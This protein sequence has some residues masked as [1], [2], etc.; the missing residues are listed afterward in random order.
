MQIQISAVYILECLFE[1]ITPEVAGLY[2]G[3]ILAAVSKLLTD[4]SGA[5]QERGEYSFSTSGPA[6]SLPPACF[7]S[8]FS[9][10]LVAVV[11]VVVAAAAAAV[12][13]VRGRGHHCRCHF[14][15]PSSAS[16]APRLTH[17][18]VVVAAAAAVVVVVVVD[19]TVAASLLEGLALLS[20]VALAS[21]KNFAPHLV[22]TMA[23]MFKLMDPSYKDTINKG[24]CLW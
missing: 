7:L 11:V 1:A 18:S 16:A 2:S 15:S 13:L 5:Q 22:T 17:A 3:G 9:T 14:S 21:K 6:R 20:A 4:S 24:V 10:T 12:V 23:V 8:C 19:V